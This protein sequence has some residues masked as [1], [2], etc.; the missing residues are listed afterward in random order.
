MCGI[1]PRA[2]RKTQRKSPSHLRRFACDLI[3]LDI[4][5]KSKT[6]LYQ[7]PEEWKSNIG[8]RAV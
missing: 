7:R 8:R 6:Q 3:G 1:F 2:L 5:E 4:P